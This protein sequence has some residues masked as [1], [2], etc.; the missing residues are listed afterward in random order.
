M[1]PT[2]A[3]LL[4]VVPLLAGCAG[5]EIGGDDPDTPRT[6]QQAAGPAQRAADAWSDD[7]QLV[8]AAAF[9]LGRD[10]RVEAAD[11]VTDWQEEVVEAKAEGE[12]EDEEY[13]DAMAIT[14]L[15]LRA[16]RADDDAVG[17]GAAPV[18]FFTF[19]S[20]AQES[21]LAVAVAGDRVVF[22]D[23]DVDDFESDFE[24]EA[25]GDWPVDSDDAAEAAGLADEGYDALRTDANATYFHAL[26]QGEDGP[27]WGMGVDLYDGD[28]DAGAFVLLSAVDASL[29][30][31]SDVVP[32]DVYL[33][34]EFG[35]DSGTFM[36]SV[37]TT[38]GSSFEV[39]VEGHLELA[40]EVAVS[41][42]PLQPIVV[43]VTD[44]LGAAYDFTV[45]FSPSFT[46]RGFTT[47]DLVT[48]GL[49]DV[50]MRV[51]ASAYS[52][53]DLSWCT[54]GVPGADGEFLADACSH[55]DNLGADEDDDG[56]AT[57]APTP[58]ASLL[59]ARRA[60]AFGW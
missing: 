25:L 3:L 49:Y 55:I 43:T 58:L 29:I 47:L 57:A 34:Q 53:W 54:D 19:L 12:I 45:Q 39:Q 4:L 18:W 46:A 5:V 14:D 24:F 21:F 37:Q 35:F 48:P 31:D 13:A 52:G 6:A 50:Q 7:A 41:P 23:E 1:R 27:V 15:Y 26:E 11:E 42:P 28:G 32:D 59:A 40:V 2:P 60:P 17:D 20:P 33:P 22:Q 51:G 10:A 16:F 38:Q 56:D 36:A 9:E 44:P 30:V 8:S